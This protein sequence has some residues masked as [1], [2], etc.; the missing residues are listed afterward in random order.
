MVIVK[1][2]VRLVRMRY[3]MLCAMFLVNPVKFIVN[4]LVILSARMFVRL[5]VSIPVNLG[6]MLHVK[7]VT[8]AA[9]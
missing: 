8:L 4:R 5:S 6:A 9:R 7:P 3:V 2:P 1:F